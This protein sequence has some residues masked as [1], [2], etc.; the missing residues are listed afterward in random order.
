MEACNLLQKSS[1]FLSSLHS[2]TVATAG[3]GVFELHTKRLNE[4][5]LLPASLTAISVNEDKESAAGLLFF[6]SSKHWMCRQRVVREGIRHQAFRRKERK[7]G[8]KLDWIREP[9]N[10]Q[11]QQHHWWCERRREQEEENS[12]REQWEKIGRNAGDQEEESEGH[13]IP[14]RRR[15]GISEAFS[16][17]TRRKNFL[18]A[19]RSAR[20]GERNS[21]TGMRLSFPLSLLWILDL[22][23]LQSF[24]V[25]TTT[26]LTL[27]L[28][29]LWRKRG[30][31]R[32]EQRN[33]GPKDQKREETRK[34]REKN[35]LCWKPI[36]CSK[37]S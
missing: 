31:E 21:H 2:T 8:K 14:G 26:S 29:F 1:L 32:E 16:G 13:K 10:Y 18:F 20:E 23:P 22:K 28:W 30:E 6:L 17:I 36:G 37:R 19:F 4:E 7:W 27:N 24:A 11:H 9:N 33:S 12:R 15:N 5:P 34:K 25:Q 3:K 35:I